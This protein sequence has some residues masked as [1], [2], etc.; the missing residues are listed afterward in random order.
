MRYAL[1]R[2]H[3]RSSLDALSQDHPA[4][5]A[6]VDC[7]GYPE[8]R[9]REPGFE[10]LARIV[11]GQQV[12]VAAAR[13]I[14]DRLHATLGGELTPEGLLA[15]DDA[16][17]R[18]VGLSRQKVRYLRALSTAV[19]GGSLPVGDLQR[20]EDAAVVEHITAVTGFGVWSAHMYLM[21]SLGR[22]DVWP[23]GDL[24]VRAGFG[25]ILG[26]PERPSAAETLALAAPLAPYRSAV[27]LLCWKY[28]SEA[29][30]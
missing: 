27:A 17:L 10:A 1:T 5:A 2:R 25:R 28:Y 26:L 6:A 20:L 4:I 15:A 18:G 22:T 7:V 29:P 24:A 14:A 19:V 30:L 21:F 12:S 13:A 9:R 11:I 8:E 16:T 3:I 23:A